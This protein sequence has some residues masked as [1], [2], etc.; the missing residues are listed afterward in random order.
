MSSSQI[1]TRSH[2]AV[3]RLV[4]A[5][6]PNFIKSTLRRIIRQRVFIP[7]VAYYLRSS[8]IA[9]TEKENPSAVLLV[10]NASRYQPDLKALAENANLQLWSLP[11]RVQS[12]INALF[13]SDIEHLVSPDPLKYLTSDHP[14][15]RKTRVK[16]EAYLVNLLEYVK[17]I[18]PFSGILTCTFYYKQDREWESAGPQANIATFVLHKESFVDPVVIP[19]LKNITVNWRQRFKGTYLLVFNQLMKEVV[20]DANACPEEKVKVCGAPRI[21]NLYR[22]LQEDEEPGPGVV[23]FSFRH[24]IGRLRLPDI[25]SVFSNDPE[26]GFVKYFYLV[27]GVIGLFAMNN[28]QVPVYV[29]VKYLSGEWGERVEGAIKQ[30][31]G[32]SPTSIK[33]LVITDKIPA[34]DLIKR[35]RATVGVSSTTL[36]ESKLMR[37]HTIIPLFAEASGKYFKNHI[38]FQ[39]YL[40]QGI[41]EVPRSENEFLNCISTCVQ[42][43]EKSAPMPV[44]MVRDYLGFA[45]GKASERI[46]CF[47]RE[48]INR[49]TAV[50]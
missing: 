38:Y 25:Y 41:F 40:N 23:L 8:L 15:I 10:L 32:Q 3:E 4:S 31:T 12:T 36:V 37:R 28:P 20:V 46:E 34:H 48:G 6:L 19:A 44:Q 7:C 21:D 27:H 35:C 11:D 30:Y 29:K 47:I 26:H 39:K 49:V 22:S 1:L 18:F 33:N 45:D 9:L 17:G 13:M 5:R 42:R 50:S 24:A 14:E 2:L 43:K 16:L